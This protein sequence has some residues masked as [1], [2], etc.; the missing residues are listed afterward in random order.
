MVPYVRLVYNRAIQHNWDFQYGSILQSDSAD[1]LSYKAYFMWFSSSLTSPMPKSHTRMLLSC[2]G[3]SSF[4]FS[5]SSEGWSFW[6]LAFHGKLS[7]IQKFLSLANVCMSGHQPLPYVE[8]PSVCGSIFRF[9]KFMEWSPCTMMVPS[10]LETSS[11]DARCSV[12][13]GN[14]D[15]GRMSP[16]SLS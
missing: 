14:T 10:I 7:P 15:I 4:I 6:R 13:V 2:L 11:I 1:D 5:C 3:C 8:D 12:R 9:S 16:S